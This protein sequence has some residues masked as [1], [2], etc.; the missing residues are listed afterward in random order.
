M[1]RD[2]ASTHS[3]TTG[4][5]LDVATG[6]LRR[7]LTS[8][9]IQHALGE[10]LRLCAR[11]IEPMR[12]VVYQ[13]AR[14]GPSDERIFEFNRVLT[15]GAP[16]DDDQDQTVRH[17]LE[18]RAETLI[19]GDAV[20]F[21]IE[22]TDQPDE[23]IRSVLATP[24]IAENDLVAVV[25]CTVPGETGSRSG[26]VQALGKV[27]ADAIAIS[28][29][30]TIAQRYQRLE[31]A[32]TYSTDIIS[33][34]SPDGT[35]LSYTPRAGQVF[36][37]SLENLAK[38]DAESPIHQQDRPRVAQAF[39]EI[40]KN[41]GGQQRVE[42][43]LQHA[44]GSWRLYEAIGTNQVDNPLIRGIV[45]TAHDVTDRK[46][47]ED[48]LH[49]QALHDPLTQL[50]NRALLL[51]D[52]RRALARSERSGEKVGIL[53][54]DLDGFKGI[55]DHFGHSTGDQLLVRIGERLRTSVRSGETVARLGG[56][57]F[58]ILLEGLTSLND[59]ERAAARVLDAVRIPVP[60]AS[61]AVTITASLGIAIASTQTIDPDELLAR[62]DTALYSAK[63]AGRNQFQTNDA[64]K[65]RERLSF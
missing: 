13:V 20:A 57:E 3:D 1:D 62:A 17:E 37:G 41:P 39:S 23:Q 60:L 58:I 44:D 4:P 38:D 34:V 18:S 42:I 26:D 35:I 52:L 50:A 32:L 16:L 47:L 11:A 15:P 7:I 30:R 19:Q 25:L 59:A 2:A 63:R 27:A 45:V 65:L 51:N 22:E 12:L 33:V 64:E 28:T 9:D 53:Y 43:R 8:D 6:S 10:T 56:D 31:A 55:N 54:L 21:A 36:G 48:R 14:Q 49:W 40:L 61:G 24:V 5:F 29:M 46:R